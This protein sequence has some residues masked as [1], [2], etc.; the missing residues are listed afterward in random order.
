MS[1]TS[2]NFKPESYITPLLEALKVNGSADIAQGQTAYMRNQF[3]FY[4]LKSEHRRA[5]AK[6]FFHSHG[7]PEPDQLESVVKI[8]W[9]N[10]HRECQFIAQEMVHHVLRE[11][12]N[13]DLL[14]F[15]YMI[16]HK[17]W[18]D[19][20]DFIAAN[21]LGRYF[22]QHP[23][24]IQPSVERWL[25]SG[26]IWLQR[27]ALL[28]QLKYKSGLD[29]ALLAAT[30]SPL[31]GSKEFFIN[32]AV[33]WILREYSKTNPVWVINYCE[34]TTLS[35]LSRREALKLINLKN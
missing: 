15:E 32:K 29:T 12:A 22:K 14:L 26:D 1:A 8:L 24:M 18:W 21:I 30:I 16:T 27:S 13:R 6:D 19:T 5:I 33:G 7:Y 11:P 9:E 3:P 34:Q 31:L 2:I 23:E 28:F 25:K 20:V 10:P 17:S 35:G 4:G